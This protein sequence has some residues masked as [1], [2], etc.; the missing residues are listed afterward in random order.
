MACI[1]L[2]MVENATGLERDLFSG[3][4]FWEDGLSKMAKARAKFIT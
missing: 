3:M 1:R 4:M 2:L